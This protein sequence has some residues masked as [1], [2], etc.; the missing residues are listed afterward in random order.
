MKVYIT[1]TAYCSGWE[2]D[3]ILNKTIFEKSINTHQTWGEEKMP[4]MLDWDFKNPDW[5][6][7]LRK[8]KE[9]DFEIVMAPD[10]WKRNVKESLKKTEILNNH[11]RRVVL[12]IHY[13]S[14][15]LMEEFELAYPNASGF[16]KEA[17]KDLPLVSSFG[18]YITH[19][20]GGSPHSHLDL[21]GYFPNLESVDGNQ[22]FWVAVHFGKYWKDGSWIK[23]EPELTNEECFRKS[24]ENVDKKFKFL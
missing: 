11:S 14:E 22:I 10:C 4:K 2:L 17:G 3:N 16:N 15:D 24:V 5:E 20:L 13:Y 7:H 23:P 9:Y 6:E 19:I 8:T 18:K 12:P 21:S 1:H